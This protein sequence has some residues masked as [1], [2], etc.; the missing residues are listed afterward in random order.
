MTLKLAHREKPSDGP[1][2]GISWKQHRSGGVESFA[3]CFLRIS[4]TIYL[5][6]MLPDPPRYLQEHAVCSM[7]LVLSLDALL[8]AL[9]RWWEETLRMGV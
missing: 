4:S 6:G 5:D 1:G 7:D 2:E 3:A 8:K 9:R